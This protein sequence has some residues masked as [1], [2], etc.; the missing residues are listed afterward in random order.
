MISQEF[1][2]EFFKRLS[3]IIFIRRK[4][5]K[6][7]LT[8]SK[9]GA[10]DLLTVAPYLTYTWAYRQLCITAL[11]FWE[12]SDL[13]IFLISDASR[14]WASSCVTWAGSCGDLKLTCDGGMNVIHMILLL[15]QCFSQ[16]L[17]FYAE[18]VGWLRTK[19]IISTCT[20]RGQK[21]D[22]V[23]SHILSP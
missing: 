18:V 15:A 21:Q 8:E 2:E 11:L 23:L 9:F 22:T 16:C 3:G 20:H 4:R 6:V 17:V 12:V 7:M 5:S 10:S 13:F 14:L 1:C 19:T